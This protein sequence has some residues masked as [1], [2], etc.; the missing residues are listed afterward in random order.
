MSQQ[1]AEKTVTVRSEHRIT[2]AGNRDELFVTITFDGEGYEP[3]VE[4]AA[5]DVTATD[6]DF[7]VAS[8]QEAKAEI[9]WRKSRQK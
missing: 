7:L 1:Q 4:I 8:L 6:I 2:V 9:E 5:I 3:L